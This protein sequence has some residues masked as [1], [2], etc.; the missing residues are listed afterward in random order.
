MYLNICYTFMIWTGKMS[1]DLFGTFTYVVEMPLETFHEFSFGLAHILFFALVACDTIY[2][3]VRFATYV[4]HRVIAPFGLGAVD[5]ATFIN[6]RAV[7][8][9]GGCAPVG[10]FCKGDGGP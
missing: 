9:G 10:C 8:T 7:S 1:T 6:S 2:E 4:F 3:I 5:K